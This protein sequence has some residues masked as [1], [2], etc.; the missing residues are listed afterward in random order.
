[1]LGQG[2]VERLPA[3]SAWSMEGSYTLGL[4]IAQSRSYLQTLSPK[5]GTICI[6]GTL[7]IGFAFAVVGKQTRLSASL[8][9]STETAMTKMLS[10]L[11]HIGRLPRKLL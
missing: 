6:L 5:V 9:A 3:G 1:M 11:Q 8:A 7:G 2:V 4:Q 10:R